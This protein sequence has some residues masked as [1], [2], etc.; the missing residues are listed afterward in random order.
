MRSIERVAVSRHHKKRKSETAA[1]SCYEAE[2]KRELKIDK[3]RMVGL[4][5]LKF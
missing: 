4:E 3:S 1:L 5:V 2:A